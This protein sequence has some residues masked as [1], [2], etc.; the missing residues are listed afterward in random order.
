MERMNIIRLIA[1]P[2]LATPFIAN[3]IDAVKS[4][5]EHREAADNLAPIFSA[6]GIE[7]DERTSMLAARAIGGLQLVA[8]G[9]LAF[10]KAPRV[11][12]AT[13]ALTEL[14]SVLANS[15]LPRKSGKDR[16]RA[17]R[18]LVTGAGLIGGALL[19]S[20]DRAGKPSLSYRVSS[21]VDHKQDIREAKHEVKEQARKNH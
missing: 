7:F 5:S 15:P 1:R 6:A 9:L 18:D 14:P 3:G 11:S 13:L 2:L 10:G 4:P 20:F 16:R 12:A 8:G 21:W 17:R 19:A